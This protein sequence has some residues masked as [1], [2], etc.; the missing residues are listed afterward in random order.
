MC[1]VMRSAMWCYMVWYTYLEAKAQDP[2]FAPVLRSIVLTEGRSS[3]TAPSIASTTT[4]SAATS[5]AVSFAHGPIGSATPRRASAATSVGPCA[6]CDAIRWASH[7]VGGWQN[8]VRRADGLRRPPRLGGAGSVCF[9]WAI[10]LPLTG[11]AK[12]ARETNIALRTLG[13]GKPPCC[14][15]LSCWSSRPTTRIVS[16]SNTRKRWVLTPRSR[17]LPCLRGGRACRLDGDQIK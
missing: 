10:A 15:R 5:I 2:A 3:P 4:S 7:H 17:G 12:T 11:W 14:M 16:F 13:M 9:L 8:S 1:G 6:V